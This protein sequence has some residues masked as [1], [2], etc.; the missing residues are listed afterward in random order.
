MSIFWQK[1]F[2][3]D[4]L[5]RYLSTTAAATGLRP[6][7]YDA[8]RVR[9]MR[10]IDGWTGSGL[11][12]TLWPDRALDI[13][14]VW[15]K[16]IPIAWQH[17]G[18][19]APQFYE[20]S[21]LGWLR[22]FGGGLLTTCGL[23]HIGVPDE[24]QGQSFGLHGR[25]AH[26]PAENLRVWQEWQGETYVLAVEG[27]VRQAVLFG[28]N[29][30]LHRRIETQL[31]SQSLRISDRVVNEGH[32][33]TSLNLLYHCNLGFPLVSPSSRLIIEDEKI[34]PRTGVA[35]KGLLDHARF[36]EPETGYEEQV[37]FHYPRVDPE[38]Y[39]EVKLVNPELQLGIHLRWLAG[40]MPVLTQWKMMGKGEY[41]CGLE[42]ATHALASREV[43]SKQGLPHRLAPGMQVQYELTLEIIEYIK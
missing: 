4:T 7:V 30:V 37:F 15:F 21:G 33:P 25:I 35:R 13:G 22:T 14:P 28:E 43:L 17:P 19:G 16:G 36:Q 26:T 39:A 24:Y 8:G 29:L 6:F 34:E 20:P 31:G 10:G 40:P 12:F 27:E 1:A 5:A 2:A 42:P 9:G 18:L 32:Q 11:H 23:D 41:A 38:G 3:K